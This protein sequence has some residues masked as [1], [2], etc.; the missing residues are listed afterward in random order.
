MLQAYQFT[1]SSMGETLKKLGQAKLGYNLW[2]LPGVWD[3]E[4]DSKLERQQIIT[5]DF[6]Y[7]GQVK[8]ATVGEGFG[9]LVNE[10]GA[11]KGYQSSSGS[12]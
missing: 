9:Y 5:S 10:Q 2:E 8:S 1:D 3:I 11:W 7:Y 4:F 12:T 6:S